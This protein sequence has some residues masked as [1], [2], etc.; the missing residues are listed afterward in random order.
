MIKKAILLA[1]LALLAW[2]GLAGAQD[3]AERLSGKI[4][5]QVESLGEAWYVNPINQQRYY[6]ARPADAF[7]LMR[8]LGLGVADA[9]FG[10]WQGR[11]PDRLRGRILL[12]VQDQ[13]QAYYVNPENGQLTYLKRPLDAL[14]LMRGQGLGIK[15]IDLEKIAVAP[16]Y[17]YYNPAPAP[18][19]SEEQTPPADIPE[20]ET[21]NETGLPDEETTATGTDE[22]SATSSEDVEPAAE[23]CQ[24]LAEF[25]NNTRLIGAPIAT[26]T[27]EKI[28]FNWGLKGPEEISSV[29]RFSIRLTANCEFAAG[30]Y[31]F[32]A[33]FNDGIKVYLDNVNFIQSWEDRA[34]SRTIKRSRNIEA[35]MHE[36]R[37]EYYEMNRNADLYLDWQ[38]VE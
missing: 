17:Q 14:A 34:S 38:A 3:L 9:D 12:K 11:A 27:Y 31:D 15:N 10:K 37:I 21:D 26:A 2:P 5:L 1:S 24:F 20:A 18:T 8:E 16:G 32:T 29:D 36:L 23:N 28:D 33:T 19:E 30:E 6:L 7:K 4:L 25:F 13:G 35:G 22:T